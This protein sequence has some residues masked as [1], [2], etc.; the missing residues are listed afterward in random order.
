M[1]ESS[2]IIVFQKT[3]RIRTNNIGHY[4]FSISIILVLII[5]NMIVIN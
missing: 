3:H 5:K 1:I 2:S 4:F